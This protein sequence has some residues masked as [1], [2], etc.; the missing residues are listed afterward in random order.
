M[1]KL[2]VNADDFGMSEVVNNKILQSFK[3]GILRSASLMANGNSFDH[4]VKIIESN[5]ELDVGLHITLSGEKPV[6]KA[7]E[8]DS[9]VNSAG[10][11]HSDSNKFALKYFLRKISI[12]DVRKEIDAQFQKAFDHGIKIT[13]IDSHQHLHLL[14]SIFDTV[15]EFANKFNVQF[16]RCPNEQLRLNMLSNFFSSKRLFQLTAVKMGCW[17]VKNRVYG[18]A[19][20][21]FGFYHGGF[22]TTKNILALLQNLPLEGVCELM[23]HPGK[24]TCSTK[25]KKTYRIVEEA[26]TL[27]DDKVIKFLAYRN[28]EIT[29]FRSLSY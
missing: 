12:N 11:F 13:H 22:L 21:F 5:P 3:H 7:E 15:L 23:C 26:D 29:S 19:D 14:P 1:L 17:I 28:V 8:I 24:E 9:L 18:C 27:I 25:E 10:G 2:I 4:A 16:V 20:H 6:S